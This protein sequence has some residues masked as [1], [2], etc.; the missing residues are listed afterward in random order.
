VK[1]RAETLEILGVDHI[2]LSVAQFERSRI[3]YDRLMKSLGFK[4][5][6]FAIGGEPHCHYYN[7][8]LQVTIRPARSRRS[9]HD[10]YSPGLHHLCLRVANREAVDNVARRLRAMRI[11]IEGPRLWP[12]YSPDYYAVFFSDPDGIRLEVMNHV[13][14]R[15]TIRR[16][17]TQ[18]EGFT[19][20]LDR[21]AR[22]RDHPKSK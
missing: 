7:R 2:Y 10:S 15:K 3:F 20:P 8:N 17:W 21:L 11:P 13:A 1:I 14:R 4:K 12:E 22:K 18:L 16:L 6:T 9:K 5:G 19:N